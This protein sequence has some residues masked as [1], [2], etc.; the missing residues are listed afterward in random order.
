MDPINIKIFKQVLNNYP[1]L[2]PKQKKEVRDL[3]ED[4][5][6]FVRIGMPTS[7]KFEV[8]EIKRYDVVYATAGGTIPHHQVVFK[9]GNGIAYCLSITSKATSFSDKF[10]IT[11]NR[12]FNGSYFTTTISMLDLELAKKSFVFVYSEGR[13][14]F[15]AYIREMKEFYINLLK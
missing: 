4:N 13:K 6:S 2:E 14:E 10:I 15:D 5:S 12:V 8:A 9:V 1:N 3:L 11:K 7:R